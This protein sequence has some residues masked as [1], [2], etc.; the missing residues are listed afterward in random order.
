[1]DSRA[2]N[3]VIKVLAL[4]GVVITFLGHCRSR[5]IIQ[6][7]E[8]FDKILENSK[9]L[10]S[11]AKEDGLITPSMWRMID[12][13]IARLEASSLAIRPRVNMTSKGLGSC[14]MHRELLKEINVL[15][16]EV[17]ELRLLITVS[18]GFIYGWCITCT[19]SRFLYNGNCSFRAI[20]EPAADV[21][22]VKRRPGFC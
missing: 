6:R 5:F 7:M 8:K 13:T 9:R 16:E 22:N 20:G 1:M 2:L 17:E 3:L 15:V 10:H 19:S 18:G 11:E 12:S 4:I 21:V 14:R